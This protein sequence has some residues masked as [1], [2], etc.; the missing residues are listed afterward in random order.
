MSL[1]VSHTLVGVELTPLQITGRDTLWLFFFVFFCRQILLTCQVHSCAHR[2]LPA[3]RLQTFPALA[4]QTSCPRFIAWWNENGSW[5]LCR[6]IF[7]LTILSQEAIPRFHS[8]RKKLMCS[9]RTDE[10][11]SNKGK[12]QTAGSQPER[13]VTMNYTDTAISRSPQASDIDE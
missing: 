12:Q 6:S 7:N 4:R 11:N 10:K 2:F 13:W 3:A 9:W 8:S 1:F 5:L